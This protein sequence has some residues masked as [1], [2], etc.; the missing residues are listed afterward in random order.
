MQAVRHAAAVFCMACIS[1]ELITL[2]AGSARTVRGIK[3]IAGLYILAVLLSQL[4]GI[5]K[6]VKAAVPSTSAVSSALQWEPTEQQI[7]SRAQTQ[8]EAFCVEQ[9]RQKFGVEVRAS[10]TLE[11]VDQQ[12]CVTQAVITFPAA[13]GERTRKA[14]LDL[15]QQELG[16]APTG[17]EETGS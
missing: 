2:L 9:C 10:I 1:T 14:A 4:P 5:P 7:L 15:L 3:T 11:A 6:A 13:C 17:V 8:L 16:I 12:V